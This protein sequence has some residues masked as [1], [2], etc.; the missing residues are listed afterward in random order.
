MSIAVEMKKT[1]P[2]GDYALLLLLST[3]W[4]ASFTFI[5]LG[6]ETI[7]PLTFI[8]VRTLLAGFILLG[9]MKMKGV[10]FPKDLESWRNYA[11]QALLNSVFPV[12]LIAWAEQ[13]VDA[14]LATILNASSPI[15]AFLIDLTW[16]KREKTSVKKMLGVIFG[17][18]GVLL[19]VGFQALNGI[20]KELVAQ[21]AVVLAALC[22]AGAVL[23]GRNFAGENPMAPATGSLLT[24]AVMTFPFAL[25]VDRPW[26]LSPSLSSSLAVVYLAIFSTAI[27]FTLYF[28][29]IRTMGSVSTSAQAYLRVPIGVAI[30]VLFLGE[31]L[32][33]T[34]WIGCLCVMAGVAA[35]T[36]P[37]RRK[38]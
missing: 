14:G 6:V 10:R 20:G 29:L 21:L 3:L 1:V 5:K 17:M 27:A 28:R 34:A 2:A 19:I 25:I 18:L 33:S 4:G 11:V 15:F 24:G 32:S 12:A 36:I 23:W 38:A 16:T 26:T 13:T 22:F 37:S 8:T 7:P 35:M 30:G 9:V 31:S